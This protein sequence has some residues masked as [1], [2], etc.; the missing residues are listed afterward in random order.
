[1]GCACLCA[2][3]V[4]VVQRCSGAA[5]GERDDDGFLLRLG[6]SLGLAG[7]AAKEG[8]LILDAAAVD[9]RCRG[10]ALP[11]EGGCVWGCCVA[12]VSL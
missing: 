1:M 8:S 12:V 5:G 11:A 7:S 6:S 10:L 3:A 2:G 4:A 9:V